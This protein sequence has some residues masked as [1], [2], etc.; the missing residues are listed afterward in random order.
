MTEEQG[1]PLAQA[2]S[3][4]RGVIHTCREVAKNSEVP[5][6]I[7]R[8]SKKGR[9]ELHYVPRGVVG[10]I[11]PWNYPVSMAC[12]KIFPAIMTG[13]TIVLKPSPHT[14]I[15]TLMLGEI[16]AKVFPP[17]VCNVISGGNELGQWMTSHRDIKHI[18]F[19][20]SA[21]TGR[22]IME[23]G[24][25]TLKK[26][27]LELGG[28][29]AAIVLPDTDLNEVAPRIYN[30]AMYNCGQT[31]VAI[32]RVFVHDSQYEDMRRI[33]KNLVQSTVVGDGMRKEVQMGPLN[34]GMQLERVKSLVEDARKR[35]ATV[36]SGSR[37]ADDGTEAQCEG[38]FHPPVVVFDVKDEAQLVR[39]EQ[40]GPALPILSYS[41]V[42]EAVDR[43][44]HTQYGLGAS[45]W[46]SSREATRVAL[47]LRPG[48]PG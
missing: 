43:A 5:P 24:A 4:I 25:A 14:P 35:G 29:D 16:A 22:R 42:D 2:A 38:F 17:G 6:E 26:L 9:V 48:Q 47:L 13:N 15:T 30:V 8:E 12:N 1:K 7:L 34:N 27:T 28:N 20:G 36:F 33:M 41:S 19:T 32:K 10:G 18:S 3:E 39:E 37:W 23:S 11:T 40:F 46:G 44:N 21:A 45:V 31:C